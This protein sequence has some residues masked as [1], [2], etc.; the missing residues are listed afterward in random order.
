M[1]TPE[2]LRE[3][4][5]RFVET[6]FNQ[7]DLGYAEGA[8]AADFLEHSPPLPTMGTDKAGALDGFKLFL[9][10]SDDLHAEILDLISDGHR[11]AIRARYTGTDTGGFVPGA[12]ATNGRFDIEGIDVATIGEDGLFHE[13]Y[14]IADVMTQLQQLG[15]APSGP[16]PA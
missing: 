3:I 15:L 8:L 1:S 13:H 7:R 2:E 6:V 16:P 12:P 11:V 4:S 5:R 10:A 14:G 9:D